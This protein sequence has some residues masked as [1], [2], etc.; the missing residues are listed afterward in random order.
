MAKRL[1]V[2]NGLATLGVVLNHAASWGFIAMF[3]WTDRYMAVSVPN[4][5]QMGSLSYYALRIIEQLIAFSVPAFLFVSGF[6]V[7]FVIGKEQFLSA[8]KITGKRIG[9]LVVPYL[10]WSGVMFCFSYILGNRYSLIRYVK[11][12][13][14]GGAADPYYYIP[15]IIQLFLLA[16]LFVL[17]ARKHWKMLLIFGIV[18]QLVVQGI[19]YPLLLGMNS[20]V[21]DWL[22]KVTPGWFFPSKVFWFILGIVVSLHLV[23]FKQWIFKYRWWLF[24][25]CV[26]LLPGAMI[27]WESLLRSS[28]TNWIP[29]FDTALDSIYAFFFITT[30]INFEKVEIPKSNWLADLG[31]KSYGVYLVHTIVLI[32]SAKLIFHVAPVILA[33]QFIFLPVLIVLG[34]GAPLLLMMF[35]KR[36][37][38]RKFYRTLFG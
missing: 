34:L 4:F 10:I 32:V 13:L 7:A 23:G 9:V 28:N 6:F 37:P 12:L 21:L 8:L 38:G 18:T 16:P 30:F 2:L 20:P 29:Y 33:Y 1:L 24:V 17:V 36:S 3:W 14:V 26:L 15:L 5:D 31:G 25:G 27:E 19:R 22:T 11:M 35:V